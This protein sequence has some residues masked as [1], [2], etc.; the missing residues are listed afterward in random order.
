MFACA[1][2]P[3]P[4]RSVPWVLGC[5]FFAA[6]AVAQVPRGR[7]DAGVLS[8][9]QAPA[10]PAQ[11]QPAPP[12]TMPA[13]AARPAASPN[14]RMTPAGFRFAGN[15][16]FDAAVLEPLLAD[17]LGRPTDLAGLAEAANR[18]SAFYRAR[19]Y[20]LTEAYIPEQSFSVTGGTV[21]IAVLEARIGQVTV[22]T[23]AP[24]ISPAFATQLVRQ[25]LV[26]GE[27][28]TE[29]A[30]DKAVLLLRDLAGYD[31]AAVV[32]PGREAGQADVVVTVTAA[33]SRTDLSVSVDNHGAR[34]AGAAR[35]SVNASV[36]NL[37]G[38]GDLLAAT[39]QNTSQRGSATYRVGY[40]L[41][42]GGYGTK[43]STQVLRLEYAL[44][45]QFTALGATGQA[46]I[47]GV[48]VVQ[49]V[50]RS[51]ESNLQGVASVE[52]KKLVDETA[53]PTLRSEREILSLKAGV[54][55]NFADSVAGGQARNSYSAT[56]TL[57][58]LTLSPADQASDSGATGLKTAGT[59]RKLN[60]DY[61]RLQILDRS[62]SVSLLAQAQWASKNLSSAEKMTLGGPYGVRAYP[63]GEGVGDTGLLLNLEYRHDVE[64]SV[65]GLPLTLLAFYDIGQVH[66]NRNG[67]SVAGA[68][69][70]VTLSGF[71]VGATVG[72]S[73]RFL[74]RTY[75]AWP[76][77]D[78]P[79]ST[80][81][82]S[83]APRAWVSAQT[84]F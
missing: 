27:A 68:S 36:N 12:I 49:P 5:L 76:R 51:R 29:Y 31:A 34:A 1:L 81:D 10:L 80:G 69:N 57:G 74:L 79:P 43:V 2:S 55:G 23:E 6:S 28:V 44:G 16:V 33:G 62:A 21:T 54:A 18:I 26:A 9:P 59:F 75:L 25:Q 78:L 30:L 53:S 46:D 50:V 17:W 15:R 83:R 24:E 77:N 65:I 38:R 37:T 72:Q 41:P 39:V 58:Q 45:K 42:V 66:F 47:V 60:L 52:R 63:V 20:L 13:P 61:Q 8:V 32:E 7:P 40:T 82:G 3:M 4:T 71:G 64:A 67:A 19:G 70:S 48:S 14:V 22:K 56:A 84:W 35:A 73:G 11:E